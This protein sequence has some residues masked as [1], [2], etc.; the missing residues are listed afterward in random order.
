MHYFS[1]FNLVHKLKQTENV[2]KG[3]ET[4]ETEMKVLL[5]KTQKIQKQMVMSEIEA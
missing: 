4:R 2:F 5:C 1:P 3:N